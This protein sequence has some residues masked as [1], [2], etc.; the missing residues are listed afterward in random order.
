MGSNP[1]LH[2]SPDRGGRT[3]MAVVMRISWRQGGAPATR[4]PSWPVSAGRRPRLCAT[5]AVI[6]REL[7]ID[8][9]DSFSLGWLLKVVQLSSVATESSTAA[10]PQAIF[11]ANKP[12]SGV[13]RHEYARYAERARG[14]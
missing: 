2:V 6:M 11:R 13:K 10:P 12:A 8:A 5:L 3:G 14:H 4:G 9:A 1:R 7:T